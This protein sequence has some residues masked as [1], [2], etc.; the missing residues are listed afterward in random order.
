M[1]NDINITFLHTNGNL[2]GGKL[3]HKTKNGVYWVRV[4]GRETAYEVVKENGFYI[5][6]GEGS[7]R[8]KLGDLN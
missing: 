6:L 4:R 1:R 3:V 2:I 8:N 7:L 5:H